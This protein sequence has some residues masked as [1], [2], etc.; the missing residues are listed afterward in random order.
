MQKKRKYDII[1]M[2]KTKS[3]GR[4]NM[5]AKV[6]K[7]IEYFY[8]ENGHL[9]SDFP[10]GIPVWR[11]ATPYT[12]PR[13]VELYNLDVLSIVCTAV[14][15]LIF[16]LILYANLQF[17]SSFVLLDILL[18]VVYIDV[19]IVVP[20]LYRCGILRWA[21]RPVNNKAVI[22]IYM[23]EFLRHSVYRL[24]FVGVYCLFDIV[25]NGYGYRSAINFIIDGWKYYIEE[26]SWA[27]VV[28]LVIAVLI[29]LF[30]VCRSGEDVHFL[31]EI[32]YA[33]LSGGKYL[34]E[35][36]EKIEKEYPILE[37]SPRKSLVDKKKYFNNEWIIDNACRVDKRGK[38]KFVD[39]IPNNE[40]E[41]F[42][43]LRNNLYA[44]WADYA[45]A[46]NCEGWLDHHGLVYDV[47]C[48]DEIA[49]HKQR[50]NKAYNALVL[51][52]TASAHK[53]AYRLNCVAYL[54]NVYMI[55]V[56]D[57]RLAQIRCGIEKD[58]K[59]SYVQYQASGLKTFDIGSCYFTRENTYKR[60][61]QRRNLLVLESNEIES[62]LKDL[63]TSIA[64]LSKAEALLQAEWQPAVYE[65]HESEDPRAARAQKVRE[66]Q[67]KQVAPDQVA[68]VGDGEV[69]P[70]VT[71]QPKWKSDSLWGNSVDW[72]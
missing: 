31:Q 48:D 33:W 14:M 49:C 64:D 27:L 7:E 58:W 18:A 62:R 26:Q 6:R 51:M 38:Y 21:P 8:N 12:I 53:S 44:I 11:K 52:K 54:H 36:V 65:R 34:N 2:Q 56:I 63:S 28:F 22:W 43:V 41:L 37:F 25:E 10:D 71:A 47:L 46:E 23:L 72:Y 66:H 40:V 50:Y 13:I 61:V 5:F 68:T 9:D 59:G 15:E 20:F 42:G 16:S 3:K 57:N 69:V 24:F 45:D 19:S 70:N 35:S 4:K 29:R 39:D 67:Q 32:R 55:E 60:L 1:H 30:F 17:Y